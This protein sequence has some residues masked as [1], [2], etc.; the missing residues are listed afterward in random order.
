M[1]AAAT[2]TRPVVSRQSIR[3]KMVAGLG[4]ARRPPGSPWGDQLGCVLTHRQLASYTTFQ[5][6]AAPFLQDQDYFKLFM[7]IMVLQNL[8]LDII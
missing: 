4:V 8:V 3:V 6:A 1:T 7:Q 2:K 5:T